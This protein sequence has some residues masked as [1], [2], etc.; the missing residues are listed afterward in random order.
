MRLINTF[1]AVAL[2]FG[3]V[4]VTGC[5]S[6]PFPGQGVF[7]EYGSYIPKTASKVAEGTGW[8]KWTAPEQGTV[9]LVD[10]SRREQ[11]TDHTTAPLV[12]GSAL[13]LRG[14]VIDVDGDAQKV[15][16]G[17]TQNVTPTTLTIKQL[18]DESKVELWFDRK[19]VEK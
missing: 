19:V 12:V 11:T 18:T 10:T 15:R 3:A 17:G 4:G 6:D 2:A 7:N 1:T 8:L 14:Q 5:Q 9:Y 13:V 16:I